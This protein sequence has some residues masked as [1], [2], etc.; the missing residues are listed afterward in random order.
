MHLVISVPSTSTLK[1]TGHSFGFRRT[2]YSV[3]QQYSLESAGS[4]VF[5]AMCFLKKKQLFWSKVTSVATCNRYR[6]F[7]RPPVTSLYR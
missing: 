7:V 3:R 5:M 6:H 4:R 1:P 2:S